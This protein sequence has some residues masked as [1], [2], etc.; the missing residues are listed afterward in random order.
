M[1]DRGFL[2]HA[3]NNMEIDYGTMAVCCASLI[4]KNLKIN[5]VALVTSNDTI[6][7][8]AKLHGNDIINACFDEIIIVDKDEQVADRTFYDT[9][10]TTK[11]QPYYNTNRVDSYSMSPFNETI[12]IDA[13]YLVL[14]NSIDSVW[15]V[16]ENMLV[17]KGVKD[18]NHAKNPPGFDERFNEMGIPLYWATLVYFKKNEWTQSVFNLMKFIKSNYSYYKNLYGTSPS[19]FFRNDYAMSMAIHMMDGQVENDSM[20]SFPNPYI[21][22]ATEFDDLIDFKNGTAAF[23]SEIEQGNFRLH[24][25][26]SNVHVMNKWSITRNASKILEYAHG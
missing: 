22:V 8:A 6:S 11:K 14:D 9:R 25:V 24:K 4:K 2:I 5:N 18:L 19:G 15:G 16:D 12:L 10:Y 26:V 20:R 17:N 23:I 7:W 3:Y 13:D 21:L 1:S